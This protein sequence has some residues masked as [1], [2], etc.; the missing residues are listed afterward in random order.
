MHG[1]FVIQNFFTQKYTKF[2]FFIQMMSML[3]GKEKKTQR[4]PSLNRTD[5]L[6]ELTGNLER[7][8]KASGTR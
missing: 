1:H 4:L 5:L 3:V 2:A 8:C 6:T 7:P